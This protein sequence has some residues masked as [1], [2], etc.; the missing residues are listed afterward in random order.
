[1]E[2]ESPSIE[3]EHDSDVK[4]ST[5]RKALTSESF[6]E[7]AA[8]LLLTALLSGLIIPFVLTSVEAKRARD[9]AILAAQT[10]LLS[11]I[12][13]TILK[14]ETLAA[15]VTWF[16]HESAK[17]DELHERA[18]KRYNRRVVDVVAEWRSLAAKAKTLVSP[19]VSAKIDEFL[20]R[21]F[22]EQDTPMMM[23]YRDKAADEAWQEQHAKNEAMIGEANKL[24]AEI[25]K[26]MD[27]TRDALAR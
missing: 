10:Q 21:M 19:S 1:M 23:L 13:T 12:S 2:T 25:A 8:L 26:D 5:L 6:V 24:I 27:L 14:Y 15:D 7:H 3:K 11:D 22:I 20:A 9:D 16:K 17:N 18:F 4:A